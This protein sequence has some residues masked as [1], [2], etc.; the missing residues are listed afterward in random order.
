[1]I[2]SLFS[3]E[4]IRGEFLVL[5]AAYHTALTAVPPTHHT[6]VL[7]H[8]TDRLQV[9]ECTRAVWQVVHTCFS[10]VVVQALPMETAPCSSPYRVP[11]FF[12]AVSPV[13]LRVYL[14]SPLFHPLETSGSLRHP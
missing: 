12:P 4:G 11:L 13:G 9:V 3:L 14:L 6:P 1:M 2:C 5:M 8:E 7:G 10:K